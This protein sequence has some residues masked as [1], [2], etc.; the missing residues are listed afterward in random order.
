MTFLI[1]QIGIFLYGGFIRVASMFN[2]KA[3]LWVEGRKNLML[4]IERY[5]ADNKQPVIWMHCASLGEFEQGR[6]VLECI[7]KKF[8]GYKLLLTF[9][10]PSG[11]ELRKNYYGADVIY[12]L[13]LDTPRNARR[14]INAVN[15][16]V[17]LFVKYEFWLNYIFQCKKQ[18]VPLLLLSATF[19]PSQIFFKPY[20]RIFLKALRSFHRLFVQ[21]ECSKKLLI[22]YDV[23][24]IQ[25]AGDTRF[26]RVLQVG[27]QDVQIPFIKEFIGEDK[28]VIAG[29]T[30]P[31][32]EELFLSIVS[33]FPTVKWIIVPHEINASHIQQILLNIS[34][35][36]NYTSINESKE[37]NLKQILVLDKIGLL[38]A[39][40]RYADI[41]YIGGGFGAGIHNIL[42]AAVY[43]KPILFG[44]NFQKFREALELLKL[45]GAQVVNNQIELATILE[46]YLN[47][48][49]KMKKTGNINK[50]YVQSNKG[51]TEKV[52][53][54]IEKILT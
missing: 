11:Y 13:P 43:G 47:D 4:S 22:E 1:Y 50:E 52:V 53:S 5:F 33:K 25:V 26:D 41:A 49:V 45:G 3:A 35:A 17:A 20:G 27:S 10:S 28:C 36:V 7:R 24:N 18:G 48:E 38:S 23:Q 16:A 54:D 19:R 21:D 6:P 39:L 14:F 37:V 42:E 2:H 40:Y 51:A 46:T 9:F 30:W 44:P 29:S 12:Y 32:D 8:P 15:P 34:N 31:E